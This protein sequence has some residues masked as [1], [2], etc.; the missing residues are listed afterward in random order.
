MKEIR[1][2]FLPSLEEQRERVSLDGDTTSTIV[3]IDPSL[4]SIISSLLII[5]VSYSRATWTHLCGARLFS[6][7]GDIALQEFVRSSGSGV[8]FATMA[9]YIASLNRRPFVRPNGIRDASGLSTSELGRFTA[10]GRDRAASGS[11]WT[12]STF[13]L[14]PS[15]LRPWL[16]TPVNRRSS[17]KWRSNV[18]TRNLQ[19]KRIVLEN[20]RYTTPRFSLLDA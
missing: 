3:I 12:V 2:E 19:A 4:L 6:T 15:E 9:I 8:S 10:L 5:Q 7:S 14:D 16:L 17:G 13:Q 20:S 11:E 18:R 1:R